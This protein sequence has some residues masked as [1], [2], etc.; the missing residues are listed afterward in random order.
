MSL[1]RGF[2]KEKNKNMKKT[3]PITGTFI[4]EITYDIPSSN[5]TLEQWRKDLDYMQEIGIDTV[6]FIRGGFE[7]KAVFP[8]KV[9][10]THYADDFAGFIFEETSKRNMNVYFGMYIS[11]LDWNGGEAATEIRINKLF[12]DEVYTRYGHY[13]SFKGWYIPQET[14]FDNLNIGEIMRGMSAICKDKTPDKKVLISPFFNTALAYSDNPFTPQRH[15]EEWDRLFAYG[16]KDIDACAFQDG[17]ASIA[18]MDEFYNLTKELCKKYDIE[19]WVNAE[20]FERDVRCMYYPITFSLLKRRLEKHQKYAD[21]IITFEFSHF[22][23]PQSI[24]PSAHNLNNLYK[25]YYLK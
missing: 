2:K 5:W 13:P 16:G 24:Y 9:L 7:D 4:D 25:E 17:T 22:L 14:S 12:V 18:E 23:S 20:T 6:I 10:G 15:Y 21:K 8:S 1:L 11:N 19:H 3:G